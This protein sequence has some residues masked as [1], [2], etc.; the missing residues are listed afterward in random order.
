M[1]SWN[2]GEEQREKGKKYQTQITPIKPK[3]HRFDESH[4]A[5]PS[6]WAQEGDGAMK[7]G[8]GGGG[9]RKEAAIFFG[10]E[11]EK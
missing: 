3:S 5:D 2:E 7:N 9:A 11:A 8:E 6:V 1:Y 4:A 10:D